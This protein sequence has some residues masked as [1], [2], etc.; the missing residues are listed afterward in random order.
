MSKN[1]PVE[2][3]PG[4]HQISL[5]IPIKSLRNVFVYLAQDG[6]ENLLIDT[7]W[8]GDESYDALVDALGQIDF[9]ID[10]IR[11]VV[12]SHLHPDHFGLSARIKKEASA[13]RIFMHRADAD[14]LQENVEDHERFLANLHDWLR[15]HGTPDRILSEILQ[16]STLENFINPAKPDVRVEGGELLRVGKRF[17]FEVIHTPGHTIGQICLYDRGG[18][19]LLFSGDHLLPTITPNVSLSPLYEGDPLG[20]YLSSLEVLRP[21]RASRVLPSHE[22][23]FDHLQKRLDEIEEH[24]AERL[25]N[26]LEV[27]SVGGR[28]MSGYEVASK[29]RWYTGS[30]EK[31]SAWEKRAA[32]METLAHLEYLKRKGKITEAQVGEGSD[33][34][35]QYLPLS[36]C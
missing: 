8:T 27:V 1:N 16:S 7:G 35:I 28:A 4:L 22:Y 12:I 32:V 34:R 15:M 26:T 36:S 30:W 29:L 14:S 20:D 5:P 23:V 31:L 13:C 18:S 25:Q 21:I 17:S 6:E 11:N 33:G 19:E 10:R 9:S 24:H 3:V 2:I